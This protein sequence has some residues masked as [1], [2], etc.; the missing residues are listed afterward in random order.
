MIAVAGAT[1][2]VGVFVVRALE[3]RGLGVVPISRANGV[4]LLNVRGLTEALKGA[5]AVID[6]SSVV[7]ARRGESVEFFSHATQNILTAE[8]FA[9]V[10]HHV[11]LSIVGVDRVRYGYYEGKHV[12]EELVR[13]S[14][15]PHTVLRATQLHE[16]AGQM[17][18]RMRFGP[19]SAI[20]SMLCRPVAAAEVADLLVDIADTGPDWSDGSSMA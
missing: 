14:A 1:G 10:R 2:A 13:S 19:V 4:D 16:F 18:D 7:T 12:Q 8:Q 17:L 15:I 20:P 3:T 9:G 6:V 11:A 5:D